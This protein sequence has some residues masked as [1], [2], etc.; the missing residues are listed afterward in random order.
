MVGAQGVKRPTKSPRETDM[1]PLDTG[2]FEISP[3]GTMA[4]IANAVS[5]W[6]RWDTDLRSGPPPGWIKS[7]RQLEEILTAHRERTHEPV[8]KQSLTTA[9]P[10]PDYTSETED[11]TT[12]PETRGPEWREMGPLDRLQKGDIRL[13][14]AGLGYV[15]SRH[16]IGRLVGTLDSK[17]AWTRRPKPQEPKP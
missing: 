6:D 2:D 5:A 12:W 3:V 1:P 9:T 4:A 7:M 10:E 11:L 14:R 13:T 16:T 8:V 17:E 15:Y